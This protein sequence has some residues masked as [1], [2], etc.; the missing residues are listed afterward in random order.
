MRVD[1][2]GILARRP[3][4]EE[5][6][7]GRRLLMLA[8][9]L[10]SW[11]GLGLVMAHVIGV[12]GWAGMAVMALF[13]IGLPW[14]LLAFWNSVIGFVILRATREPVSYTNPALRAT[15][16]MA[17]IT[18]RTAI[19]I[20]IRHEDVGRVTRRLA[21]MRASLA[22][23]G[24]ESLFAF[25][26]LSD[27]SR[28]EI[29]AAEVAAFAGQP[30]LAYRRRPANT[31]FKAGNL[32]EFACGALGQVDFMLALDADSLMSGPAILRLVRVMEA[33]PLLGILQTLVTGLPA[34]SAF[35]RI[36]QF[37]MRHGMRTHTTGIAWWQGSSGP[38]WGHNALI[39][40]APFVAHCD[41]PVLPGHSPLSG[42]IL[43]H[44]Q[45]EA[46]MMRAAGWEVR[47]IADE[48]GSWEENPPRLPDFI[49]RDLRWAQ[50][51]LQYLRLLGR[52]GLRPMGR[53]QL[54]NAVAMY[55]GAPAS[56]LMLAVG[57]VRGLSGGHAAQLPQV[58]AFV[59]YFGFLAIGFAPRLLGVLDIALR[60]AER[61]RWGGLPRLLAGA[62]IDG[63][64]TLMIGPVMMVAQARFI[65]GLCLGQR[66]IW[67]AQRRDDGMV[68]WAEAIRG[69]WP[70]LMFGLV[71]GTALWRVAP[72][73]IP[74]ALPTL[75]GSLLAIPFAWATA[76]PRLG[77]WMVRRGLCAIPDEYDPAPDVA[78][79]DPRVRSGGKPA[80]G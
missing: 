63:L 13:L 32:R 42:P 19:C 31:G 3:I 46:A 17:P 18:S 54:C 70:Q 22:G 37:G 75:A 6:L 59:L 47:V 28:P 2:I 76:S 44:D 52:P 25:H 55:L 24:A 11:A 64:F 10:G 78:A 45:V 21:I 51:N 15:E 79:L 38:Y 12:S 74:W 20:A 57:L 53:F 71:F 77:R 7:A 33:N 14:T 49:R 61:R 65:A 72:G 23:T 67:E 43:S 62:V 48:F 35:A 34:T 58:L 36:F 39:R 41:L 80:P 30:G 40:L 9:T 8:L 73:A 29:V 66:I 60:P 56:L 16:P 68:P 26:I 69:L 50:G 5:N 4:L 1:D 27:S